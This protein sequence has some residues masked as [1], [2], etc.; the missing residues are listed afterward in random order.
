MA[1]NAQGRSG[2]ATWVAKL[3]RR[4]LKVLLV[5]AVAFVVLF[6]AVM[7]FAEWFD[8]AGRRWTVPLDPGPIAIPMSEC[9][10]SITLGAI[11]T[12]AG[13]ENVR[14]WAARELPDWRQQGKGGAPRIALAKLHV[15]SEIE[16]VNAY[17]TKITPWSNSGS[18]WDFKIIGHKGD[19]DFTE[20]V[21]ISMLYLFGDRPDRLYPETV[22]YMLDVLLIDEG[23]TPRPMVPGSFGMILDTENHHLMAEGSRYLKNQWLVRH[24]NT[25]PRFDNVGGGL[26]QWLID[27]L[28]EMID[29]GIY[30]FNSIPYLGYTFHPLLNLEAFADSPEIRVRARH[31]LDFANLQYA[32]G[33]LDLR[34]CPPFRRQMERAGDTDLNRNA[35]T[36]FMTVWTI[37]PESQRDAIEEL[38]VDGHMAF[39]AELL[40]YRLPHDLRAW[41]LSKPREYFV[42]FGRGPR[43]TPELYSGGPGYLLTAGGVHRG[44]RSHI[45]ARPTSLMLSDGVT[46]LDECFRI[47]G[48][49]TWRQWNNTGVHRRFACGNGPVEVPGRYRPAAEDATWQVFEPGAPTGLM[50]AAH[51]RPDLG[52]LAVFP[53]WQGTAEGLLDALRNA[54]PDPSALATT[55]VRPGGETVVFDVNARKG[56]WTIVSV[57]GVAVDRDYDRWPHF[58]GDDLGITFN[59]S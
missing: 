37:D 17:L 21:L 53:E 25:D 22:Q 19:Y 44:Y 33:S 26:E 35:H 2:N 34:R 58:D 1:G 46:D 3:G 43:A 42:T 27:Y 29:E 9:P 31:L 40:P 4:V 23:T 5:T 18:S 8:G 38:R 7:R 6:F 32:L 10:P 16:E 30:E 24:G 52:L 39:F 11:V 15:G 41:T 48:K 47:P 54:N 45:V 14:R 59:R 57:D 12:H 51:S 50:V 55:F 13:Q 49:G 20:T 56:T 28:Q 36:Q